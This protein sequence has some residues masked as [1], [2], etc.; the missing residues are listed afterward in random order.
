MTTEKDDLQD[1]IAA[2]GQGKVNSDGR[3][4]DAW[5]DASGVYPQYGPNESG[6]NRSARGE[7]I[8][9]LD[10]KTTVPNVEH[11]ITQDTATVYPKADVNETETGHVI[12]INDTPGGERILIHHNTG[13]GFDIRPDGTVVINSK[14]NN[15]ESTDGNK[16]M[17]IGGDG[18]ITVFGNLDLD[19]RGD[20]NV[21]VG[22]NFNWRVNGSVVGNV[23]GSMISRI[24]GSVRR[25]ITKDLQDQVLG[26]IFSLGLGGLTTYIKGNYKVVNHGAMSLF[27]KTKTRI[28][29]EEE[30]D[31]ASDNINIGAR[32]LSAI[33][34]TG[35]IGGQNVI[36]YNYNM[37][38][39]KSVWAESMS[40]DTFH[41]DLNGKAKLAAS[42]EYQ[43]YPDPIG[44]GG[45][46]TQGTITETALDTKAT[47]L[48]TGALMNDFLDNSE[49]GIIKINIDPDGSLAEGI[50]STKLSGGVTDRLL[51][52]EETRARLRNPSHLANTDF[53]TMSV[54]AGNLA[55]NFANSS[56][57]SIGRVIATTDNTYTG[58]NPIG[59][60]P[61]DG[62]RGTTF[63]QTE[64]AGQARNLTIQV[65]G[66]YNPSRWTSITPTT[67]LSNKLTLGNFLGGYGDVAN[68]NHITD[69]EERRQ[70]LRN[71]LPHTGFVNLFNT[72][73]SMAGHNL[74]IAE[75]LYR[76]SS[77][78]TIDPDSILNLRQTGKAVAYEVHN[79]RTGVLSPEKLFDFARLIK[80]ASQFNEL[81]V[82]YDTFSPNGAQHVSLIITTP[83]IPT[84]LTAR[85]DQR[86]STYYN[87]VLQSATSL[88]EMTPGQGPF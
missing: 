9:N 45:T 48:P 78:E 24:S 56:P 34:D 47:V 77:T 87:E 59:Q 55:P 35:T 1:R 26:N 21:R 71:L 72:L 7:K 75:G 76:P 2:Q 83:D 5:G 41:G 82:R 3:T 69:L 85:F 84:D 42:S 62:F 73:K 64:S 27:S 46:G 86:L 58:E 13:A 30:M 66:R 28:S 16:Y 43:S 23:V 51:N 15:V 12:E 49:S 6:V 63:R 17:A 19:V 54:A 70:I 80:N 44:G 61:E 40:A 10:V 50:D 8:N 60:L 38:T 25:V 67:P 11:N 29:S 88:V 79:N 36:M 52:I 32:D 65:E 4:Q 37:H 57:S 68:I 14:N 74:V 22:G 81:S 20:M 39:E 18:K 53:Y 33:A 31:I